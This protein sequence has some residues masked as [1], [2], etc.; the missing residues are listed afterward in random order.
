MEPGPSQ[1]KPVD[2]GGWGGEVACEIRHF[3][4]AGHVHR[5]A[6]QMRGSTVQYDYHG[7][8]RQKHKPMKLNM[9]EAK[10]LIM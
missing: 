9:D 3:A 8:E 10:R 1:I 5:A 7:T 2:F 6:L 4:H